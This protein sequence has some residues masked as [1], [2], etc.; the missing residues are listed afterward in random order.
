MLPEFDNKKNGVEEKLIAF[1]QEIFDYGI[2]EFNSDPYM[3]Y[4][5]CSLLN[6][7]EFAESDK[8]IELSRKILDRIN[9][10]YALGSYGMDIGKA[11]FLFRKN[12]AWL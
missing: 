7:N 11:K 2:Y 12:W 5:Y 4:T 8:I 6:L 3:G 1:L 10:Q 9:W